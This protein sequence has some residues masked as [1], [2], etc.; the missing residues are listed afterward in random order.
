DIDHPIRSGTDPTGFRV[1]RELLS[2]V[3][4][5]SGAPTASA[6]LGITHEKC[7]LDVAA[8]GAGGPGGTMPRRLGEGPL[9][10]AS[11]RA[12]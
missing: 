1:V 2:T 12:R 4:R 11:H 5:Q 3:A 7:V 6:R 10:L 8:D 9:G